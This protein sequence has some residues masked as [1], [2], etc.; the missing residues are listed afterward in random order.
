MKFLRITIT[1]VAF[2]ILSGPVFADDD[3]YDDKNKTT[4]CHKGQ[5]VKVANFSVD[6][7]VNNHGDTIG[8]C[9]KQRTVL[10]LRCNNVDGLITVS[11]V[12]SASEDDAYIQQ[13]VIGESS[14]ADV[15][16][17]SLN[18]GYKIR[19]VSTGLTDGEIEYFL[20]KKIQ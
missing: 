18:E 15:V 13:L 16:A 12:S 19:N 10:M 6:A 9:S 4:L 11:G 1:A 5:T 3:D 2:A 20:A 14:C 17:K 8:E 7:H